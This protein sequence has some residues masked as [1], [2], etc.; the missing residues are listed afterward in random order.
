MVVAAVAAADVPVA[1]EAVILT[2]FNTTKG[3]AE[4][5]EFHLQTS[6]FYGRTAN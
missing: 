3:F 1:A 6:F 5:K 2:T 4:E